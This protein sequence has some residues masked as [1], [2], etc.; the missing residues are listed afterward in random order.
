MLVPHAEYGFS[1]YH[2]TSYRLNNA[3]DTILA[4]Y[5]HIAFTA[6]ATVHIGLEHK[7]NFIILL[8]SRHIF[9]FVLHLCFFR[10]HKLIFPP[11]FLFPFK[12]NVLR[13]C[14]NFQNFI[15]AQIA[16]HADAHLHTSTHSTNSTYL[17]GSVNFLAPRKCTRNYKTT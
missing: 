2:D 10:L 5:L 14:H 8:L 6:V 15:Q 13:Y 11:Y 9:V 4:Q 16:I 3:L 12:R 7:V 17:L 1:L